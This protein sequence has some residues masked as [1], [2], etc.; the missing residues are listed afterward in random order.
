[1]A[2]FVPG[3]CWI[4]EMEPELGLGV[5]LTVASQR[6]RILFKDSDCVRCYAVA[7]APLRRVRFSPGDSL[8]DQHGRRFTVARVEAD[9]AGILSYRDGDGV[10]VPENGL[11]GT[12]G[13][14]GPED[15]LLARRGDEPELFDL[16]CEALQVRYRLRRSPLRGL[17][18]AR[19]ELLPHQFYIA[20]EAVRRRTPRLL[21]SDEVGLGKTV[22]ACLIMHALVHRGLAGRV[23]I[24]VPEALLTQWFVELLR[25]FNFTFTLIHGDLMAADDHNPFAAHQFCL[26]SLATALAAEEQGQQLSRAGW[27]LL[28]IDEA[29]HLRWFEPTPSREYRLAE[30]LAAATPAVL[31]LTATPEH[32][33]SAGHFARLRLLDP[34]RYFSLEAFMSDSRHYRRMAEITG[35]LLDNRALDRNEQ[36]FINR[37]LRRDP[38]ALIQYSQPGKREEFIQDLLDRHGIGRVMFRNTRAAMH[39]F[40]RRRVKMIRLTDGSV[41]L[42]A[43]LARFLQRH[44]TEKILLICGSPARALELQQLLQ[45]KIRARTAVFHEDMTLIQR[46]RAAAWFAEPDGAQ[47]LLCSEIGS[48]G[49]NFQF[50][51][52]LVLLDLPLDPELLEQ[53]IGRLDRIGQTEDIRIYVP[54]EAGTATE[55]LARWYHEGLDAFEHSLA[56]GA[57]LQTEFRGQ[58]AAAMQNAADKAATAALLTASA[59]F[60]RKLEDKLERGRDKL[61]EYNSFRPQQVAALLTELRRFDA[62]GYLQEFMEKMFD[63]FGVRFEPMSHRSYL[64]RPDDL[65]TD[66]FPSLPREGMIATCDR[67]YALS[68]DDIAFLSWDHPMVLGAVDLFC[69]S[70]SGNCVFAHLP[71]GENMLLLETVFMLESVA[72]AGL[73][74]DRF[75]PPYPLRVITDHRLNDQSE[76]YPPGS[77]AGRLRSLPTRVLSARWLRGIVPGVIAR[78]RELAATAAVDIRRHC[79][80]AM[81]EELGR[82]RERLLALRRVNDA[83]HDGEITAIE[84][85]MVGLEEF[86]AAAQLRLDAVRIIFCGKI[87]IN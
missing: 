53:R 13:L 55:V 66:A 23:L 36:R 6:V 67:T 82:E 77:L 59:S 31:L 1:M 19:V 15:R 85:Q 38:D 8:T 3:Q 70:E 62:D 33:G 74:L 60:R 78:Q 17:R 34:Q 26:C 29:H 49:R 58:L 50:A 22:E 79:T 64:L 87:D 65:L 20:A 16:R 57:V 81:H 7:S 44:E 28:I 42:I 52:R 21:L 18:G 75:L 43:W 45:R 72:P 46:D 48:E 40:P 9:A 11:A 56:C 14:N 35:K 76:R 41:G 4:S 24:I 12:V 32:Y 10:A 69:G 51:H 83:I 25:K 39:N 37:L 5:V 47:L 54:F 30:K 73:R 86:I 68:R 80:A 63:H 27:D 2:D 61:L 71:G 84:R